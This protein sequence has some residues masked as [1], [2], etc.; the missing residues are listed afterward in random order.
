MREFLPLSTTTAS[1]LGRQ[2]MQA[3]SL[4]VLLKFSNSDSST[5]LPELAG[6]LLPSAQLQAAVRNSQIWDNYTNDTNRCLIQFHLQ[7]LL[8]I[9]HARKGPCTDRHWMYTDQNERQSLPQGEQISWVREKAIR[10][11]SVQCSRLWPFS[12]WLQASLQRRALITD[13]MAAK[14]VHLQM[15]KELLPKH[16]GQHK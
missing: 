12:L 8:H 16:R 14:D 9:Y 7:F 2:L 3:T 15:F 4:K 10:R 1:I 5:A 11:G 6:L 13:L